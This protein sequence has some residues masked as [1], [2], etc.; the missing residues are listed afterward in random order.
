[1]LQRKP[2]TV[3][4]SNERLAPDWAVKQTK[5]DEDAVKLE[6]GLPPPHAAGSSR[7]CL[8]RRRLASSRCP[9]WTPCSSMGASA[10]MDKFCSPTPTEEPLLEMLMPS[11]PSCTNGI[12]DEA[13]SDESADIEPRRVLDAIATR[14]KGSTGIELVRRRPTDTRGTPRPVRLSETVRRN[15]ARA[16]MATEVGHHSHQ[17]GKGTRTHNK[18]K[19][20]QISPTDQF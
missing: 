2:G 3:M 1:M 11:S 4:A 19:L 16:K 9:K 14:G 15:L 12:G 20:Y 7:S 6:A 5:L 17:S 13:T 8:T 18:N 10:T